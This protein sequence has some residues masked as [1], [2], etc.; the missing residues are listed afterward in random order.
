MGAPMGGQC[1][2]FDAYSH[3]QLYAMIHNHDTATMCMAN[4]P[5]AGPTQQV[6][7]DFAA[8]MASAEKRVQD[9]LNK[10]GA[11]WEGN[12]ATQ[13]NTGVTPMS[14]WAGDTHAAGSN[15]HSSVADQSSAY[16]SAANGMPKP[17]QVT[18]T[19]N[20]DLGGIPGGIT[21]LFGGQTDQD[22]QEAAA[23]E[24]KAQAVQVMGTYEASSFSATSSMGTFTAPP[25][26]SGSV[27]DAG[28]YGGVGGYSG[29]PGAMTSS[30][31]QGSTYNPGGGG[32]N[33]VPPPVHGGPVGPGPEPQPG[34]GPVRPGPTPVQPG[35]VGPGPQPTPPGGGGGGLGIGGGVLLGGAVIGGAVGI[36]GALR[37]GKGVAGGIGDAGLSEEEELRRTGGAPGEDAEGRLTRGG[38][39]D[40]E[41]LMRR[42]GMTGAAGAR[43]ASG[44]NGPMAGGRGGKKEEDKEHK[45]A[46][47][48]QETEDVWS[49]GDTVAPSVIGE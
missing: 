17:V 5:S 34:P 40:E 15:T 48:L 7:N 36:G 38:V 4:A 49:N 41:E 19:D 43:G 35:P 13:M 10:A 16:T 25:A 33:P 24:A 3:D 44:A 27:A 30:P 14:T 45:T 31:W 37:G 47:Y 32:S 2:N 26:I 18:A 28:G 21:H 20:S 9:A 1:Y 42:R 12:A 23:K 22:K 8:L 29:G 6:W 11:S 39:L 46:E